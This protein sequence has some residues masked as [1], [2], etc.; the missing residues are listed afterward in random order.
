MSEKNICEVCNKS[1]SSKGNLKIHQETVCLRDQTV[2]FSCTY[3]SNNL[4]SKK[5]L[6]RHI[7][8]CPKIGEYN[9]RQ[10]IVNLNNKIQELTSNYA[11]Q[12][13]ELTSNFNITSKE[14]K[15]TQD[16]YERLSS[17]TN[18]K[19]GFLKGQINILKESEKAY[20]K[21]IEKL[22]QVTNIVNNTVNNSGGNLY[23]QNLEPIT[24]ELIQETGSKIGM[25]DLKDGVNGIIRKFR[26]VLK[27]RVICT[28]ATRNSLMY[29]YNGQLKRDSRGQMLTDKIVSSTE[30]QYDLYKEEIKKYY[31]EEGEKEM[32]E[33]DRKIFNEHF[34]DYR[35]YT[36]A[37]KNDV[38]SVKK[39]VS[40]KMSKKI[41]KF[42][43]SKTQFESQIEDTATTECTLQNVTTVPESSIHGSS[44]N[45]K[46]ELHSSSLSGEHMLASRAINQI[47][48]KKQLVENKRTYEIYYNANGEIVRK[49]RLR[50]SGLPYLTDEDTDP[51]SR[52]ESEY[53]L[54]S[55]S[56]SDSY[57]N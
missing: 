36:R 12:L 2:V 5:N 18:K 4:T 8:T 24:D 45:T 54:S 6:D 57:M 3:C 55:D 10:E 16:Q 21:Q 31:I 39:I 22:R 48:S 46:S 37:L 34:D 40:G 43:K 41:A 49:I 17:E 38:E 50:S 13:E 26:P 30:P 20:Q 56:E 53:E 32:N 23:V 44:V 47:V 19:I 1:F 9:A 42:S 7:K 27:N 33:F 14:L 25:M 29:N 51:S 52:E 35:D 15:N 11:K 28:D